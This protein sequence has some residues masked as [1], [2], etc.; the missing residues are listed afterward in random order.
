MAAQQQHTDDDSLHTRNIE[1]DGEPFDSMNTKY[2]SNFFKYEEK[3]PARL[4]IYQQSF[5]MSW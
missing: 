1:Q 5:W 2:P 4:L 3:A